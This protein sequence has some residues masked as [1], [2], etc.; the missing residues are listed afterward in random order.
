[1][2]KINID[3]KY[4]DNYDLEI[5]SRQLIDLFKDIN[6]IIENKDFIESKLTE[7]E[8]EVV[9]NII[10]NNMDAFIMNN[11]LSQYDFNFD[12]NKINIEE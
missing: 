7:D 8:I 10:K 3:Y 4:S 6:Y 9:K 2:A 5:N 11:I 12:N 1:M